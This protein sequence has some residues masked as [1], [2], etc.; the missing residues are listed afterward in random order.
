MPYKRIDIAVNAFSKIGSKLIVVGRG[1][2]LEKLKAMAASNIEF[3]SDASD[4]QVTE[5]LSKTKALIFPG[6]EDFGIV[7]LEAQ[8]CGK[9][10]I[11]FGKGGA[12]ETVK[13][14]DECQSDNATGI[15]FHDQNVESLINAIKQFEA[16]KGTISPESCRENAERFGRNRYK[17]EMGAVIEKVID[18]NS[19]K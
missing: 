5:F 1:S 16:R 13:G 18:E 12:L 2:E 6:E 3:V 11:A 19:A 4:E 9:P 14:L 17:Q 8:A 15:F 10:V 7:P